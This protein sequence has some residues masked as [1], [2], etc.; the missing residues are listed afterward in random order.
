MLLAILIIVLKLS[1]RKKNVDAEYQNFIKWYTMQ[2]SVSLASN[3]NYHNLI[4]FHF[5]E[6][7]SNWV[8]KSLFKH[9]YILFRSFIANN[10][11]YYNTHQRFLSTLLKYLILTEINLP[12][13]MVRK[14]QYLFFI[15]NVK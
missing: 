13:G 2:I 6:F 12:F 8:P 14:Q 9:P 10:S 7:F 4:K 3:P 5:F 15:W 1:I 11:E